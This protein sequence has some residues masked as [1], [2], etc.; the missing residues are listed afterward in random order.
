MIDFRPIGYVIGLLVAA[1]GLAMLIP[2][3]VDL[4]EGNGHAGVFL[5][6]LIV[7][8]LTGGLIAIASSNS[9]TG[10]MNTQQLFLLTS[11]VWVVLPLFGALPFLRGATD[12]TF[13][14]AY[15]EAMSGLTT[16]GSTVFT[17][18]DQLPSGLLLWR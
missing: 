14:D 12:A 7:T 4:A 9:V 3:G 5:E 10:R 1:L 18:L 13:T 6:S 15:F 16:T 2:M 11:G 8:V 17:G